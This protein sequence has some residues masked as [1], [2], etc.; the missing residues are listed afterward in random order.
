[1]ISKELE[2][3]FKSNDTQCSQPNLSKSLM[4]AT[5]DVK[6]KFIGFVR[7]SNSLTQFCPTISFLALNYLVLPSLVDF[8]EAHNSRANLNLP[9]SQNAS[10][11][12]VNEVIHLE[13]K[14]KIASAIEQSNLVV[15]GQE[16]AI[17]FDEISDTFEQMVG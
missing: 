7:Q 9:V 11:L 6:R 16:N 2:K 12:S 4:D 14:L 1:M 5:L 8:K 10:P 13:Q 3:E 17:N 15:F